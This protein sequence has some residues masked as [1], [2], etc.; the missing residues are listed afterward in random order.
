MVLWTRMDVRTYAA[1]VVTGNGSRYWLSLEHLSARDWDWTV[2]H[3]SRPWMCHYGV[4]PGG[5]QPGFAA[6]EQ[7]VR[8]LMQMAG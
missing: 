2:W 7:A 8:S 1:E 4:V 5:P 3:H 6:A